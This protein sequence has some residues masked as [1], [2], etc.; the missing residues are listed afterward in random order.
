[1]S[2]SRRQFTPEYKREAVCLAD[3]LGNSSQ[4][5][6]DLGISANL[7]HR[8]RRQLREDGSRAFPGNGNPRDEEIAR[9]KRELR[10]SQEQVAILK[11]AVGIVSSPSL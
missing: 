9:L 7:I 11:K 2:A 10:R 8:R 3:D 4:A 1:M 6:R 5:A